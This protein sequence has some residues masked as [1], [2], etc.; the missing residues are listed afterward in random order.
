MSKARR[1]GLIFI[2]YL[3][4]AE[5]AT[6]IAPYAIRA[7]ANAP[8]STPIAWKE[9]ATDVRFD[10]FNVRNVPARLAGLRQDPWAGIGTTRQAVTRAMFKRVRYSP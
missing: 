6:A 7:R 5:G 3:R 9:L 10:H 8:V 2:D 1:K 4:N